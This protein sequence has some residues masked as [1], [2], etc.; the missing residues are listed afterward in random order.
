MPPRLSQGGPAKPSLWLHPTQASLPGAVQPLWKAGVHCQWRLLLWGWPCD[1]IVTLQCLMLFWFGS[2]SHILSCGAF[3]LQW[4]L[5]FLDVE[6][7]WKHNSPMLGHS[8][9]WRKRQKNGWFLY[10]KGSY[11]M[12]STASPCSWRLDSWCW[13]TC[14]WQCSYWLQRV[15]AKVWAGID[16]CSFYPRK[17]SLQHFTKMRWP[18]V[19]YHGSVEGKSPFGSRLAFFSSNLLRKSWC[20]QGWDALTGMR[21]INRFCDWPGSIRIKRNVRLFSKGN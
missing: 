7:F 6:N 3:P 11:N 10:S 9:V 15:K 5:D 14:G 13:C 12:F 20:K 21:C 2:Y 1:F 19:K 17:D 4:L 8:E 18:E 16:C